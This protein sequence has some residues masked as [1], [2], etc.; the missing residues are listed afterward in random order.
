MLW[1]LLRLTLYP[2]Y[3]WKKDRDSESWN[4]WWGASREGTCRSVM[5][6]CPLRGLIRR[7]H[8][9]PGSYALG[10]LG[11]QSD[12]SVTLRLEVLSWYK[13]QW[14]VGGHLLSTE[15]LGTGGHLSESTTSQQDFLGRG[16]HLHLLGTEFW[17]LAVS[18]RTS[19]QPC[20]VLVQ[21]HSEN[22]DNRPQI[23]KLWLGYIWTTRGNSV[24]G[25]YTMS[26]VPSSPS[27]V[28]RT[29]SQ[30]LLV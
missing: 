20:R 11:S 2:E 19:T 15:V 30:L 3:C 10:L 17:A 16:I 14:C 26:H 7:A 1:T 25:I 4:F 21:A 28:T 29:V 12:C 18:R 8:Q 5:V 9:H 24:G 6:G 23:R 22:Y 27:S 13:W